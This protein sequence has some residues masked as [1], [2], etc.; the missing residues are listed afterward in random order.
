MG[1]LPASVLPWELKHNT[2]VPQPLYLAKSTMWGKLKL[3]ENL[4][5]GLPLNSSSCTQEFRSKLISACV[6]LRHSSC[7]KT[8]NSVYAVVEVNLH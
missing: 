3:V 8:A 2:K 5:K 7:T 4:Q 6:T 1:L